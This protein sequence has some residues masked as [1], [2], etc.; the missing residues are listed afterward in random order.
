MTEP[1]CKEPPACSRA[2]D[3]GVSVRSWLLA[4]LSSV[5]L[6]TI[7]LF[8]PAQAAQCVPVEI[9]IFWAR[10]CPHCERA[11]GFLDRLEADQP[12]V[13]VQRHEVGSDQQS[14]RLFARA[15]EKYQISDPGVPLVIA[16]GRY[17]LGYHDEASTGRQLR[18]A[19]ERCLRTACPPEDFSPGSAGGAEPAPQL[20]A[21]ISLPLLG[22][23]ELH[24]LSLPLLTVVLAA[25]DGFNPCAMWVLVFLLGLLAGVQSRLR[26]WLLGTAFVAASAL[27]YYLI[28]A[29]WLNMLRFIAAVVWVRIGIGLV[30]LVVGGWLIGEFL[31]NE[32]EACKTSSSPVR[33]RLLDS[34]R[35]LALSTGLLWSLAGIVLLAFAVNVVELLCSAGIPAVFT[36]MLALQALPPWQYHAWLMLYVFVFMLDDLLIFMAGMLALEVSGLG[37]RYA[38]WARLLGGVVLLLLGGLMIARPEWLM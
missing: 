34:L 15:L 19:V 8:H 9:H 13:S 18:E 11:L 25:A 4:L 36:Q 29:A 10:G 17:W 26:R 22:E 3:A 23:V 1:V 32:P 31:R 35:K 38:R 2:P 5:F 28:M 21:F 12:C 24:A 27:V 7:A 16:G 6:S 33:R 20:P 30:A 37:T 14:Q